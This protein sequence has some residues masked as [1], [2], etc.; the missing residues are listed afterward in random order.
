MVEFGDLYCRF[1]TPQRYLDQT[2]T[3]IS[4]RTVGVSGVTTGS[5][6]SIDTSD[7][8]SLSDGDRVYISGI[9]SDRT[10]SGTPMERLN[11]REYRVSVTDNNTFV[12]KNFDGSDI[13]SS[14][15]N[16]YSSGGTVFKIYEVTSEY[17]S[18]EVEDIR[19]AQSVDVLYLTHRNHVPRTLSRTTTSTFTFSDMDLLDGPYLDTNATSTTLTP[20]GTTGSVTLT[21]SA[22]TGI[23]AGSGFL[24][25]DVGRLIRLQSDDNNWTWGE[26][27]AVASSTIVTFNIRGN[28]LPNTNAMTAWRLG[29]YSATTGYPS[30]VVFFEDRL[31]LAGAPGA[32]TRVDMSGS[33]TYDI[34][35]PSDADGTVNDAHAV[36]AVINSKGN[37]RILWLSVDDYGIIAGTSKEVWIV[38]SAETGGNITPTSVAARNVWKNGS[39]DADALDV[40]GETLFIQKAKR[41][42]RSLSGNGVKYSAPD[43]SIVAEHLTVTGVEEMAYQADPYSTIWMRRQDGLAISATPLPGAEVASAGWFWH[44]IGEE[45]T[46]SSL[47]YGK[48]NLTPKVVRN[49]VKSVAVSTDETGTREETWMIVERFINGERKKSI[50]VVGRVMSSEQL[51]EEAYYLDGGHQFTVKSGDI[52]PNLLIEEIDGDHYVREVSGLW[53]LEGKT[54]RFFYAGQSMETK[55]VSGGRVT[56]G[57]SGTD[58]FRLVDYD[59]TTVP[60]ILAYGLEYVSHAALMRPNYGSSDGGPSLGKLRSVQ[61]AVFNFYRTRN[62]QIGNFEMDIYDDV[63]FQPATADLT[64]L[65][66]IDTS[67]PDKVVT[68][69]D[70]HSKVD[71]S[72]T[73]LSSGDGSEFYLDAD[74]GF[75]YRVDTAG[76]YDTT[77]SKY[78]VDA[79]D[80]VDTLTDPPVAM[81]DVLGS[82][83]PS[84]EWWFHGVVPGLGYMIWSWTGSNGGPV[85]IMD[86]NTDA[87]FNFGSLRESN[88]AINSTG[89]FAQTNYM[90]GC[91]TKGEN[92]DPA[93]FVVGKSFDEEY[94]NILKATAGS[95]TYVYGGGTSFSSTYGEEVTSVCIGNYFV[96]EGG[97][98]GV[99]LWVTASSGGLYRVELDITTTSSN[100]P[101]IT[102]PISVSSGTVKLAI[103]DDYDDTILLIIDAGTDRIEKW[104]RNG[105]M[106][107]SLNVSNIASTI[108]GSGEFFHTFRAPG[109]LQSRASGGYFSMFKTA[110]DSLVTIDT[111]NG[112]LLETVSSTYS[113]NDIQWITHQSEGRVYIRNGD[114]ISF[115]TVGRGVLSEIDLANYYNAS[116]ETSMYLVE[117][118]S[119]RNY[120]GQIGWKSSGPYPW[121]VLSVTGWISTTDEPG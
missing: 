94:L 20:S 51:D 106:V 14:S 67:D 40:D 87:C 45:S 77:V 66:G 111:V 79:L 16:D 118:E 61:N 98:E 26:I 70:V 65:K 69:Y 27:T 121:C 103:P 108:A 63:L 73:G 55:T 47:D 72:N 56:F 29:V 22:S 90:T 60:H 12:I 6:T 99:D 75:V 64:S 84:D 21:A 39:S 50:E 71:F 81:K 15:L 46:D 85:L 52:N 19:Y 25:T 102:E 74:N 33:G 53:H 113:L 76:S 97:N 1:Y 11:G 86:P 95:L 42:V 105:T 43:I 57:T 3:F 9:V 31:I 109:L 83:I 4:S 100:P 62:I 48:G 116:L 101:K 93:Y 32:P 110:D 80:I 92:Q 82:S 18:S 88:S 17:Q 13:S 37:N 107:W 36:A 120:D 38:R 112:A 5:T 34:F 58:A 115:V 2:P 54:I 7:T 117:L 44:E 91:R 35:S 41:K 104:T 119:D 96:S 68:E 23:N 89:K 10:S 78:S 30:C 28:D 8:H 114:T 49:K 24:T 59:D